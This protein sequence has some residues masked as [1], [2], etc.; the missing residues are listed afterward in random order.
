M[1]PCGA[2]PEVTTTT[3]T[4]TTT[5]LPPKP[6]PSG[7]ER[8]LFLLSPAVDP[9]VMLAAIPAASKTANGE[10]AILIMP[11]DGDDVTALQDFVGQYR[12]ETTYEIGSPSSGILAGRLG[13]QVALASSSVSAASQVIAR[14]FW[15][16]S[17]QIVVA[18]HGDYQAALIAAPLAAQRSAPLVLLDNEGSLES[19]C[20]DLQV[21][22]IVFVGD[23]GW[24]HSFGLSQNNLE[25]C[26]RRV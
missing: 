9:M 16:S 13:S 6:K 12:P 26:C 17:S 11:K 25:E 24:V 3:T 23:S 4:T 8:S 10:P 15:Q 1:C 20:R 18:K 7:F 21:Q 14:R 22:S 2:A 19:L 5:T